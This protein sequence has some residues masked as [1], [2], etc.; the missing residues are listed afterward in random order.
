MAMVSCSQTQSTANEGS[1]DVGIYIP[2]YNFPG[3][4]SES[5]TIYGNRVVVCN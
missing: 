1:D 4:V 3:I 5:T 2:V